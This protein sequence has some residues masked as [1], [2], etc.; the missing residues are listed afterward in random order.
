MAAQAGERVQ[1]T[2]DFYCTKCNAKVHVVKGERIPRC[3]QGH[4]EFK[5][6]TE[7]SGAKS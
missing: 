1:E 5:S 3:P 2:G 7:K 6:P 4:H